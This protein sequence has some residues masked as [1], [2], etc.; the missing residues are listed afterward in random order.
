MGRNR[1]VKLV[2]DYLAMRSVEMDEIRQR[3]PE[4]IPELGYVF[5]FVGACGLV[6][7]GFLVYKQ[8]S[9]ELWPLTIAQ[10]PF[11]GIIDAI[12]IA[13]FAL[14]YLAVAIVAVFG[15]L[16]DVFDRIDRFRKTKGIG[17]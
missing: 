5:A 8:I 1:I 9:T 17:S 14:V 10:W 2:E 16:I 13:A 12:I 3:N 7:V 15:T 4:A 11:P 6:G